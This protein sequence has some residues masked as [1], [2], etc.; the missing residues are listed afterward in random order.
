MA[1]GAPITS[2]PPAGSDGLQEILGLRPLPRS[3][4]AEFCFEAGLCRPH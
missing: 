2:V 4:H 3:L 1:E